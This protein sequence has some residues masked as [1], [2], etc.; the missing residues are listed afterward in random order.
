MS[1]LPIGLTKEMLIAIK[2][3]IR[4]ERRRANA[5]SR[6]NT[7]LSAESKEE[8]ARLYTEGLMTINRMSKE[9]NIHRN[10]LRNIMKAMGVY[11]DS[12]QRGENKKIV[13]CLHISQLN[14][15]RIAQTG[16]TPSKLLNVLL[17]QYFA[18]REAEAKGTQ[19][20]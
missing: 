1:Y 10:T 6:T 7:W 16:Y 18:K 20:E 11:E 9:F 4:E 15:K 13:V 2:E 14:R 19:V 17:N 12:Y 3:Q 5:P 8:L